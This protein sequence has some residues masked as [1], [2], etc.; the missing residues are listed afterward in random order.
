MKVKLVLSD[1]RELL[2]D[3]TMTITV[4]QAEQL[5]N[6]LRDDRHRT[7]IGRKFSNALSDVIEQTEAWFVST[8][9]DDAC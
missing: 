5:V 9:G 4:G 1:P 2:V 6:L 8:E 3:V 7:E